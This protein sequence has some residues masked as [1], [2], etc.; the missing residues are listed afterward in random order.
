[1]YNISEKKIIF[2]VKLHELFP[3]ATAKCGTDVG[4]RQKRKQLTEMRNSVSLADY[5]WLAEVPVVFLLLSQYFFFFAL[6][7]AYLHKTLRF[8]SVF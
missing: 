3:N 8:T 4:N 6:A 5:V 1:L 7:L 2:H